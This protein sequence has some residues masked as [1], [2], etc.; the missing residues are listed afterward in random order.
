LDIEVDEERRAEV[1][2]FQIGE[3]LGGVNGEE[4]VDGFQFDK[5]SV[6]DDEVGTETTFEG[7][8]FVGERDFLL[9]DDLKA[10]L[11]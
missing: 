11:G 7:E 5:D 6:F 4:L 3:D 1:G 9:R 10:G 2:E 8:T